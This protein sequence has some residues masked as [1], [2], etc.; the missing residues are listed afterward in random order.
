[1]AQLIDTTYFFGE[2]SLPGASLSGDFADIDDYIAQYEK[3]A[4]IDLLGYTLYK[5][6]KAEIDSDP[7]TYTEKWDRLVNGY[8]YEVEYSGDTHTIR[9]NG[10]VNT[11]KISLLAYYIYYHY[12]RF[13]VTHTSNFGELLQKAENASKI[14]P[15]QRL[16]NAWNQFIELRG[17]V[18]DAKVNP[19][20]YNFLNEY[21]EDP[22]YGYDTWLFKMMGY[23]NTFGI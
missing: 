19:T 11:E 21:E 12:V 8:E 16:V 23:T 3:E 4:L 7:Q 10:L 15:S 17:L 22:T 5:E 13:H 9:W 2:I 20:A 1:M 6:L 18:S 14:S